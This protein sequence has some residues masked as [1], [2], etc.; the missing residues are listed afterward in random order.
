MLII[1]PVCLV[2]S[3]YLDCVLP[4][5][6]CPLLNIMYLS[7]CV[8][9][10]HS[11]MFVELKGLFLKYLLVSSFHT[12]EKCDR[13]VD[14][15]K[16]KVSSAFFPHVLFSVFEMFFCCSCFFSVAMEVATHFI[17]LDCQDL[18]FI[19]Y[20]CEFCR[21][22]AATA[23]DKATILSLFWHGANSHRP[24]DLPNTTGLRWREG[25]LRCLENALPQARISPPSSVALSSPQLSAANTESTPEPA[26]VQELT[27]STPEPAPVQEL[28]ESTPEPAPFQE[29]TKSTPEPAP[30]QELTEST[31]EPAPFQELTESPP[32]P[33]P[34][35][36][37]TERPQECALPE[38]L[39]VSTLPERPPRV[40]AARAPSS[41]HSK[42][43]PYCTRAPP[44][45][46]TARAPP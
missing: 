8:P 43:A 45:V 15:K 14:R 2:S 31:P 29:L 46:R 39:Q 17:A 22:A 13:T 4:H 35:Q 41:A 25:I 26:P 33:F 30:F 9:V 27:E 18:P 32:E 24:V 23:L 5:V 16:Q 44:S 40:R 34:F 37:L 36:E 10:L 1:F 20:S 38:H 42:T 12:P 19:E 6:S 3:V 28:T 21:L 11:Q 7:P